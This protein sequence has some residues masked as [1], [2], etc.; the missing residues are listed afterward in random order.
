LVPAIRWYAQNRLESGGTQV[1]VEA[2]GLKRR[3]PTGL[4]TALFRIAQ[5]AVSNIAK[6]AHAQHVHIRLT[7]G[8][9]HIG[10]AVEDDGRGFDAD[11]AFSLRDS[12]RGLGLLGMRE[13]ASLLGGTLGVHSQAGHGTCVQVEV[14]WTD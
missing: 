14:P 11:E 7:G 8:G 1:V 12:M 4:E 10:V 2:S 9:G 5:E 3:L 6:H 13:R